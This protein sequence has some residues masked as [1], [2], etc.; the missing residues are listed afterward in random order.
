MYMFLGYYGIDL[1]YIVMVLPVVIFAFI[2]QMRVNNVFK[3]YSSYLLV[4]RILKGLNN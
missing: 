4:Y 1:T 2:M 3:K